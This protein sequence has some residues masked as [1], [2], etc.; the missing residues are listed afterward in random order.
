MIAALLLLFACGGA[1]DSDAT[2]VGVHFPHPTDFKKGIN[3][4]DEAIRVGASVCLG[5]HRENSTAPMCSTCHPAY[6]HL[7]GWLAGETHGKNLGG[8]DH[9]PDRAVCQ[10]CHGQEGLQAPACDS[11]HNAYPHP[12]G[13]ANAGNHGVWGLSHGSLTA[14]CG[15][16]HGANLEGNDPAPACNHCHAVFPHPANWTDKT[17]H[18]LAE[19]SQCYVCHGT[20]GTGGTSGIACAR[21]HAS[22]PHPAQWAQKGHM[23]T[24]SK[25]GENACLFCHDPGDGPPQMPAGCGAQCHRGTP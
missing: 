3:H 20:D 22:Y 15:S 19:R 2:D 13:W 11:C 5:C 6:P 17:Q 16:C 12:V 7:D 21:C 8:A 9:A 25:V 14:A 1:P 24:A 10:K 18:P 4:G 23:E